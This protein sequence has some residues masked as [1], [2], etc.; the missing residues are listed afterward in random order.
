MSSKISY[1]WKAHVLTPKIKPYTKFQSLF[2]NLFLLRILTFW[3]IVSGWL[4]WT[5]RLICGLILMRYV[6]M[7]LSKAK[8]TTFKQ[9]GKIWLWNSITNNSLITIKRILTFLLL[10]HEFYTKSELNDPIVVCWNQILPQK[11]TRTW[12]NKQFQTPLSM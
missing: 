3:K 1:N 10:L 4:S 5:S 6:Q 12:S 8:V 9:R 2:K 11:P 7:T